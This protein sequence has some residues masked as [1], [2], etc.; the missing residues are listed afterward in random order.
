MPNLRVGVGIGYGGTTFSLDNGNGRGQVDHTQFAL[1]GDYTMGA[2]YVDAMVGYAYGD[3][4]TSRNVSLPGSPATAYAHTTDN[5][6]LGS[7]EAG[8]ALPLDG[9]S[10]TPFVGLSFGSVDQ[11]GFVEN[12]AGPLNLRVR[13]QSASSVRSTVGARVTADVPVAGLLVTT[14]LSA[15]WAHE[16]APTN[17]STVAAFAG[18][19][20]ASFQVAGAKVPG[21]SAQVGFGLATAV[22][23]N[24]SIYAHYDGDVATGASS[25]AITAGIRIT[26]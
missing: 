15:G 8:Y 22:F 23:A 7:V 20:T 17:R 16:Y 24:T 10:L 4:T 26:W 11:N 1:Y 25:N 5:Q 18:A 14:D 12:G 13:D 2:V 9:I 3:G 6:V 19:P 21:D